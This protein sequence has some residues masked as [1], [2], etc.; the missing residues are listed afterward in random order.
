MIDECAIFVFRN[1]NDEEISLI[2]TPGLSMMT[3]L[4]YLDCEAYG[5]DFRVECNYDTFF[6]LKQTIG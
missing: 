6:S 3:S 1:W 2:H 4:H 5:M